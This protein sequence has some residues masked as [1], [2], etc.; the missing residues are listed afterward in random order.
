[1]LDRKKYKLFLF[2]LDGTI[3]DS[4]ATVY[5]TYFETLMYFEPDSSVD[6]IQSIRNCNNYHKSFYL[7]FKRENISDEVYDYAN[8]LY[9]NNLTDPTPIFQMIDSLIIHL[10]THNLA[11]GIVTT[12]RKLFVNKIL[13]HYPFLQKHKVLICAEDV[14]KGKPDPEGLLKACLACGVEPIDAIY[15]GDLPS[16]VIAA[17]TCGMDSIFVD[18]GYADEQSKLD[19]SPTYRLTQ[20]EDLFKF[21]TNLRTVI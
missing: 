8:Q 18:Y 17:N 5:K 16:D 6:H 9:F 15:I 21:L 19:I 3:C 20:P 4:W 2:D 12:K 10:N 14:V 11:W 7:L 13:E 1:M